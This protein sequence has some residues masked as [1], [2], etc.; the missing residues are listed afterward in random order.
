[1]KIELSSMKLAVDAQGE[2]V[3]AQD[4]SGEWVGVSLRGE[5]DVVRDIRDIAHGDKIEVGGDHAVA[6]DLVRYALDAASAYDDAQG[7]LR[8]IVESA[9]KEGDITASMSTAAIRDTVAGIVS[10]MEQEA[11]A[12]REH[13]AR[14]DAK[15]HYTQDRNW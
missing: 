9:I 8:V 6:I 13:E 10:T 3:T 14:I 5:D 1:M 7:N 15:P 11:A 2:Y 12:D 4:S